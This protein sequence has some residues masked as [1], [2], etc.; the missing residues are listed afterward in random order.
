MLYRCK[1]CGGN[2]VYDP[3]S[4]TM[5]CPHCDGLDTEEPVA[6]ETKVQC[7]NCGAPVNPTE[8]QSAH[9]C[10]HCGVYLI[11]DE[12]V[13][14][15][16]TPHLIIPFKIDKKEA[17]DRLNETF[18]SRMFIPDGFMSEATLEKMEGMYVPFYLYDFDTRYQWQGHGNQVRTWMMGDTQY[19]ETKVFRLERDMRARFR[20]VPADASLVMDDDLMDLME[21]YEYEALENF[22]K[23]YMSGFYAEMYSQNDTELEDRAKAKVT[24]ALKEKMDAT[25]AEYIRVGAEVDNIQISREAANYALLPVWI[26]TFGYKGEAYH[27]FVNGQTGK[28]IGK[29]PLSFGKAALYSASWF[30]FVMLAGQLIRMIMEVL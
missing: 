26:Y 7:P 13:E 9:R 29:A 23:K 30:A 24:P 5:K 10:S 18:H 17:I 20:K 25:L 4:K 21:P 2:V 27:F 22:Q 14:G 3:K 19:T 1:N 12:R 16:Y 8:F 11:V 15:E 28:V 6:G